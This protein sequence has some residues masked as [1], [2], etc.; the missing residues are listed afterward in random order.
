MRL[1]RI[2][3]SWLRVRAIANAD[4]I[5]NGFGMP[6]LRLQDFELGV[7]VLAV[8]TG[9]LNRSASIL[10]RAGFSSRLAAIKTVT[11]TGAIFSTSFELQQWLESEAVSEW[12]AIA[13]WPTPETRQMWLSFIQSFTPREGGAWADRRYSPRR[14]AAHK[15]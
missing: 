14:V 8:E 10:I 5:E 1:V 7:A 2:E 15:F 9:T 13:G 11:D 4:T 12:S 6:R 3:N